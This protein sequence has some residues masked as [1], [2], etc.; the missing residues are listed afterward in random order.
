[1]G[2]RTMLAGISGDQDENRSLRG[3]FVLLCQLSFALT[4]LRRCCFCRM[5]MPVE[6]G[7]R[8]EIVEMQ[9]LTLKVNPKPV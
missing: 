7:Q 5:R 2:M 4:I 8:V 9:G 3:T 6:Q 1:M